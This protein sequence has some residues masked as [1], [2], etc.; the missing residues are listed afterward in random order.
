MRS[1]R[2]ADPFDPVRR[3]LVVGGATLAA[4][5]TLGVLGLRQFIGVAPALATDAPPA[6][7]FE[8]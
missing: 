2:D 6:G 3:K 8:P 7:H 4:V 5:A 1:P